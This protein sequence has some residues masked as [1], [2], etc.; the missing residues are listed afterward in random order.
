MVEELKGFYAQVTVSIAV[1][2]KEQGRKEEERHVYFILPTRERKRSG[3]RGCVGQFLFLFLFK[4]QWFLLIRRGYVPRPPLK[5]WIALNPLYT[6]FF[7]IHTY[8]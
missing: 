5:Q 6:T 4:M 8:L 7:P 1:P 3:G 2:L